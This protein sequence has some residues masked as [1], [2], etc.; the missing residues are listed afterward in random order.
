M[1]EGCRIDGF[2]LVSASESELTPDSW[3]YNSMYVYFCSF[4]LG[5]ECGKKKRKE[6]LIMEMF[7]LLFHIAW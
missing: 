1:T 4:R 6:T 7:E 3:M 5:V 2:T